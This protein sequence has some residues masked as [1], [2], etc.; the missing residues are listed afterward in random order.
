MGDKK[1][2]PRVF[3]GL[4]QRTETLT[5]TKANTWSHIYT[6]AQQIAKP[7]WSVVKHTPNSMSFVRVENVRFDNQTVITD[8]NLRNESGK[9]TTNISYQ[10][11]QMPKG[12]IDSTEKTFHSESI[13]VTIKLWMD[14]I[15]SSYVCRGFLVK[16]TDNVYGDPVSIHST[17]YT[18]DGIK[19]TEMRGFSSH[20]EVLS[21]SEGERCSPCSKTK[22]NLRRKHFRQEEYKDRPLIPQSC[23][24]KYMSREQLLF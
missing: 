8:I 23:N 7:G 5:Q 24:H 2:R 22:D 14:Y 15:D 20:C 17:T 18:E 10:K 13:E 11:R 21:S 19:E 6:N 9:I 16:D 1:T 3:Q 4:R 12:D